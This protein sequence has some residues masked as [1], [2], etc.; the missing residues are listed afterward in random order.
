MRTDRRFSLTLACFFLSGF[1]AL[2]FQTA[3]T[4]EFAFVFG[5]SDLA[6]A[7][8]LAGYMA[9][10]AI[11]AAAAGRFARVVRRPVLVYAVL[12]LAIGAAA[13]LVPL[14]IQG[15]LALAR[16]LFGG[17]AELPEQGD[18]LQAAFYLG[19]S[20]AILV[21]PTSLMGATLPLLARDAVRLDSQVGPRVGALYAMNTVGAVAGTL[22]AGFFLLP[23]IG[24]RR[25]VWAGAA[26]NLVV[27]VLAARISRVASAPVEAARA[28]ATP[29]AAPP[30]PSGPALVLPIMLA[31]GAASF[32]YEVLWTRLLGHLVGGSVYAFATMLASFLTGIALGSAYAARRTSSRLAAARGLAAA[33]LGIALLAMAAFLALDWLPQAAA[34]VGATG[35]ATPWRS[36]LLAAAVLVPGATAIGATFPFAVRVL[37]RSEAEAAAASARVYAWNTVGAIVGAIGT[38]FFLLPAAGYEGTIVV[39]VAV[40]LLLALVVALAIAPGPAAR[41]IALA[42]SLG[43]LALAVARPAPPW[44]LLAQS[45]LGGS[46]KGEVVYFGVGRSATVL[47]SER[48]GRWSLRTNGLP[49]AGVLPPGMRDL[50]NADRLLATLPLA[51]HPQA[52]SMLVVGLGGGTAIEGLP[53]TVQTIDVIELEPEVVA[54]NRAIAGAR[55]R[56]P[57]ADPRVRIHIG[58]ARGALALTERRWDVI[59]SQPSHPWTAGASHL[60]TR[61]FFRLARAHLE[62]DGVFLQWI[63]IPFVDD[64]LLRSLVRT[65]GDAF[66]NVLVFRPYLGRSL[67]FLAADRP[68]DLV[69]DVAAA[70]AASPEEFAEVG[71]RRPEDV[72][73]MLALDAEGARRFAGDA[74]I[75][76]DDANQLQIRSPHVARSDRGSAAIDRLLASYDP[77]PERVAEVD[78]PYLVRRL[79]R[80]GALPRA[81][82]LAARLPGEAARAAA[83]SRVHLAQARRAAPAEAEVLER[84]AV[85]LLERALARHPEDDALR[86]ALLE[87]RRGEFLAGDPAAVALAAP[88]DGAARAVADGWI[89]EARGDWPA[90][91]ALEPALATAGPLDPSWSEALRLRARWRLDLLG[92]DGA[93]EA[94]DLID[95]GLSPSMPAGDLYLRHRAWRALGD[96]TNAEDSLA[97]AISQLRNTDEDRALAPQLAELLAADADGSTL[98]AE[99]RRLLAA[100]LARYGSV[101]GE[102]GS[103]PAGS[104]PPRPDRRRPMLN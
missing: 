91:R 65:L 15:T 62:P 58:D 87:T 41:R 72:L 66:G 77:L 83:T 39:A 25:T 98:D 64:A 14:A 74:P 47:L 3:W 29:A 89:L 48:Q 11:G 44:R 2:L 82:L 8:V 79:V 90:L 49:E 68:F 23:S 102:S 60:Y 54:A 93:Q 46:Q 32:G 36:A 53:R 103:L 33:Q 21:V 97:K 17:L 38:G 73:A 81:A 43:L 80:D 24:L 96:R 55:A 85:A 56:D 19:V 84:R 94:I 88:L 40:N 67:L 35:V 30:A 22:V 71:L 9:G 28:P 61:E 70:L 6:V 92:A 42:S 4:R 63:G 1:A 78:G 52:R 95:E 26:I 99:R 101:L 5:T 31:S 50:Q 86:F 18:P 13:L 37:A 75:S 76:T 12:E 7:T 69:G 59:V 34:A 45:P 104:D 16:R 57:L 51:A 10:L 100:R 27:F 20:L